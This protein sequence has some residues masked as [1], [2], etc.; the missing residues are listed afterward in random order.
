MPVMH[1][2]RVHRARAEKVSGMIERHQ[3]HDE[4]A[5]QVNVIQA[6]PSRRRLC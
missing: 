2:A 5:E 4:A 1:V 6:R 3:D